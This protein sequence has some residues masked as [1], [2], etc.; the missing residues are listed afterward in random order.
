[1]QL[2][3]PE[4]ESGI[5]AEDINI[6]RLMALC[7][8]CDSIFSFG[9]KPTKAKRRHYEQPKH[10]RMTNGKQLRMAFRTNFRLDKDENFQAGSAMSIV[11]S[12]ITLVMLAI[13]AAEGIP[14]FLPLIFAA[15]A[16][17]ALYSVAV[18]A[19]NRTVVKMD[20]ARL[21]IARLPLPSFGKSIALP[22]DDIV[23]FACEETKASHDEGFDTPRF[24]VYAN[25]SSGRRRVVLA[26]LVED[27]GFFV[28]GRLSEWLN[29]TS[30]DGSRLVERAVRDRAL[31]ADKAKSEVQ[32][33]T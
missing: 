20:E 5:A 2:T 8:N 27:Y 32:L 19:W 22:L 4:C 30:V 18:M 29:G 15:L 31:D 12:F 24:H 21:H 25:L 6:Q 9:N 28:T 16:L 17:V 14:F 23:S 7:H 33:D 1:M 3:C 10:L 11:F 26:D 13:G